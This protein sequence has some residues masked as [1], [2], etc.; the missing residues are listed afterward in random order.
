M[1]AFAKQI[2][3]GQ[4]AVS[5]VLAG[6]KNLSIETA[7]KIA[8]KLKLNDEESEYFRLL[9]QME[10][11]KDQ[12]LKKS[13]LNRA[14]TLSPNTNIREISVDRFSLIADWYHI[15]IENLT[16]IKNFSFTAAEIATRLGISKVEA[17]TAIERLLR[18]NMIEKDE[19]NSNVY[20][21]TKGY[22]QTQSVVPNEALRRFH[23]QML[24]KTV[25]SIESQNPQEKFIGT[26]T[27]AVSEELL[28]KLFNEADQFLQKLV[29]LAEESKNK[30]EVYHVGL[31]IFNLIKKNEGKK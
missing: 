8:Q 26:E 27:F 25:E 16:E 10:A 30:T 4:S 14:Q 6:K 9:V 17:E 19:K 11:T 18:L 3:L 29:Q 12:D 21:K 23:R 20:R 5:Q 31:Q 7:S 24:E 22:S 2:G 1:R 15:A 13:F 28:P